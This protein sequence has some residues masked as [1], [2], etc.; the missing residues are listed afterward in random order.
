MLFRS[1]L[2]ITFHRVESDGRLGAAIGEGVVTPATCVNVGEPSEA[3]NCDTR[4]ECEYTYE[5][6][7]TE[8]E[9]AIRTENGPGTQLWAPLVQYNIF[10]SNDEVVG[11]EYEQNVRALA[12]PDYSVIPQ[13]ATGAPIT[14]GNGAV[15]GEVH[16]C[17]DV[18]LVNAV[19]D[20]DKPHVITT[21]F[22]SDEDN[23]LP[24]QGARATSILG[25]YAALDVPEG[26]VTVA[27]GGFVDGKFVT[28]GRHRAW[29]YP[30]T[31]TSVTFKGLR[32]YQVE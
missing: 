5:G 21:Y 4:W 6:V 26:P 14:P 12:E 16:D 23:P 17:G 31:V 9:L 13:T 15:A 3:D 29:V 19:A 10:I 30:D 8:T 1:D 27:A 20:I 32:P 11:G 7:P 28:L 24:D 2:L 22:T 25:L 18:R